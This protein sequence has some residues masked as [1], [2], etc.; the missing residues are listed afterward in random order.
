[1]WFFCD[2]FQ[3]P[4][5]VGFPSQERWSGLPFPSPG[6]LPD[7]G[8]ELS[9]PASAGG[10]FTTESPGKPMYINIYIQ[11]HTHTISENDN[12]KTALQNIYINY[13]LKAYLFVILVIHVTLIEIYIFGFYIWFINTILWGNLGFSD[14]SVGKEST[15]NAGEAG[16]IPGWGRSAGEG[17][18]YPL[19]FSWASLVV[20]LVKNPPAMQE[21]WVWSLGW[22]DSLEKEKTTHSSILA[23]RIPWTV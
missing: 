11:K 10:V 21:T 9:S 17:I 3:A 2:Y 14:S 8:I 15:C 16:L 5:S 6:D 4:L 13:P 20:Q 22:E 1:M 18:G 23:W 12:L 7:P 19:Q